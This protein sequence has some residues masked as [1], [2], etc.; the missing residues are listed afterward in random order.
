MD[1]AQG[2]F[3]EA[4]EH[5]EQCLSLSLSDGPV[6]DRTR[7]FVQD[8]VVPAWGYLSCLLWLL[9]YP[10]Q[11]EAAGHRSVQ[12]AREIG[13]PSRLAFALHSELL[14]KGL[15]EADPAST[16]RL[17]EEIVS[18]GDQH[19]VQLYPA[20]A[21]FYQGAVAARDADPRAGIAIMR[22]VREGLQQNNIGLFGPIHLYHLAAA[23]RRCKE[24]DIALELLDEGL[25]TIQSTGERMCEAELYRLK[26]EML[27]ES[28]DTA[29][30]EAVLKSALGIAQGQQARMWELR[31]AVAL[32]RHRHANGDSAEARDLLTAA[33]D[34]FREGLE[35][36]DLRRAKT[37]LEQLGL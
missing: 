2:R 30:G 5:M 23:H 35:S 34:W 17:A 15:F 36:G 14:R 9:G 26:G 21:R 32:A 22:K 11:A 18:Y 31:A 25:R 6:A 37:V 3:L 7:L 1:W 8:L 27:L 16:S 13:Q 12:L 19:G 20:W 24:Y 33:Y 4:R 28:G 10:E 29:S